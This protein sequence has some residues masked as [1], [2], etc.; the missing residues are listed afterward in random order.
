MKRF[1][2]TVIVTLF[3]IGIINAHADENVK[4]I[5]VKIEESAE[6][7]DNKVDSVKH[8]RGIVS[9]Y[10][11]PIP[12]VGLTYQK[13]SPYARFPGVHRSLGGSYALT[14][15]T[16]SV[17]SYSVTYP[18]SFYSKPVLSP[19]SHPHVAYHSHPRT[20]YP[21]VYSNRYPFIPKQASFVPAPTFAAAPVPAIIPHS[22]AHVHPV[23]AANPFAVQPQIIPNVLSVSPAA[24]AVFPQQQVPTL[25][26]PNGWR[27][28]HPATAPQLPVFPQASIPQTPFVSSQVPQIPQV[29]RPSVSVLPP[30]AASG[31][32]NTPNVNNFYLP[33]RHTESA[34][35]NEHVYSNDELVQAD[36]K[37]I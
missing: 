19:V 36:G 30:L 29:H 15:G 37:A 22:H 27:T 10:G 8:K 20:Y 31:S 32:G 23:I 9:G 4:D 35:I 11:Y 2:V 6:Q 3:M 24:P 34:H 7:S 17:H 25:I 14:P 28:V 1:L 21:T 33:P 18:K 13:H 26:S 16:A 12:T 5:S